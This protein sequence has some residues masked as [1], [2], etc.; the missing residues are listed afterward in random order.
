M[1]TG[2]FIRRIARIF[3]WLL[4]GIFVL[5]TL[6]AIYQVLATKSDQ[7]KYPAPGQ[8]VDI[9]GYRLHIYCMGENQDG[10]PTVLLEQGAGGITAAWVRMLPEIAKVTRVCAYDRAGMGWSDASSEPRD[11]EHIATELHSLLHNA[12]VPG[13]Y[14][15]VGW[16]F[17]GLYVREYRGQYPEEVSGMVLLDSSHP[18]QWTST[19]AGKAQYES[20]AH[21]YTVAPSLARLGV[22]RVMGI[23]NPDSG[24]PDPQNGELKASSRQPRIGMR[25]ALSF[26]LRLRLTIKS[27]LRDHWV[28]YRSTS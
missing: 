22:M 19:P 26:S 20:F 6:G 17:G 16:S 4:A 2:P 28:T 27:V 15:L 9:G 11:A 24:L 12:G 5:A 7:Q 14:V 1:N 18:D 8:I 13:P 21:M 3:I 10:S 25:K 23:F